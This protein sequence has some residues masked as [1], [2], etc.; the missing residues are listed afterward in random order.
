MESRVAIAPPN[1][2]P[3]E[4]DSIKPAMLTLVELNQRQIDGLVQTVPGGAR[5]VQDIYPLTPLQEGLLF[6]NLMSKQSDGYIWSTLLHVQSRTQVDELIR[7]LQTAIDR[8]DVLRSAMFWEQLPRPVQVVYRTA[9][10]PVEELTL[11]GDRCAINQLQERAAAGAERWDLRQAP[12]IRLLIALDPSGPGWYALWQL[13]HVVCDYGSLLTVTAECVAYLNGCPDKI[14]VQGGFRDHVAHVLAD[15]M[16][17]NAEEFFRNKFSEISEP[18]A[19]FNLLDVH[20]DG[21]RIAEASQELESTFG[22]DIRKQARSLGVSSARLFHAAWGLVVARSS[23]RNDVVFGTVLRTAERKSAQHQASVGMFINTLPLRLRLQGVTAA[24][25]IA[26]TQRELAE[27]LQYKQFPLAVAQRASGILGSAPLFTTLLNFRHTT[28]DSRADWTSVVGIQVV[29]A[30]GARTNY[31]I[32]LTVDDSGDVFS[33]TAQTDGQLDPQRVLAYLSTATQS[34]LDALQ[35]APSE[36][37]L[38]LTVLPESERRQILELFNAT[39][40]DY[41]R[42]KLVHELFEEQ[43][44]RTP[45]AVA[46]EF[47]EQRL[48]YA[49]LN[50]GANRLARYLLNQGVGPDHVVG[51]CVERGLEMVMGLLGILKSGGAFLPLDPNYPIERLRHMLEDAVP[52]IV[53]TQEELWGLL[54][55]TDA[56]VISLH[57][58]LRETA[59]RVEENVS[60]GDLGLSAQNLVYIIYTSGSTGQPKGTAM[61][62]RSMV[63]LI[64]WHRKNFCSREQQRVLQ[65]AAL[66]FD[67][68]FQE[69]F[70]TLCTGGTLVLLDEWLR[71]DARALTEFLSHHSIQRL[72]VP[73]LML[74]SLAECANTAD[75]VPR[76]LQD[77]ITAGE[78]LRISPE[79][80]SLFEK[81]N[82]CRLH[83]HYGP[84]E[85]HVVTALTL[86]GDSSQWPIL[87]SIGRPISNTQIYVLDAQRQPVPIDVTGEVHIGGAGVARGYLNQPELTAQRF[88]ADPFSADPRARLY[89]TGDLGRWRAN[90]SLEY[91]GRND[92]QVKIR[93][94]RVEPG[95]IEAQLTQHAYVKDAT[96]IAREDVPGQKRLV[97]YVTWHDQRTASPE[98]LRT[99]LKVMLPEYMIP[100]A[101]VTV[102]S[103]PLTPNGKLDREGLPV[104][105]LGAYASQNFEPPQGAIEET[106]AGIWQELLRVERVGRNDNFFSLGGHSLLATRVISHMRELLHVDLPVGVL[107]VAPTVQELSVRAE[108]EG[109]AQSAQEALWIAGLSRH[110][111]NDINEMEDDAVLAEVTEL[112]KE[113]SNLNDGDPARD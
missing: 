69:T 29:P 32:T 109:A 9:L 36:P 47:Q 33:L 54:P 27:L 41:P 23:G 53:L 85:T 49:E 71:R 21:T 5:N 31:P 50:K 59:G 39:T 113:F 91:L 57:A 58:M 28:S 80:S 42:E 45:D 55:A 89:R 74:Q 14:P 75:V 94:F 84:T 2:I 1:L 102:G 95:E 25:L 105:D 68:A 46:V 40:S 12:L 111:R 78:Q 112:Q 66:S 93:G 20:G 83:N 67:V 82:G 8:H 107:F 38:R 90:G 7:A 43:V 92:D 79:I 34:L 60:A 97:A 18:T 77:V 110:L 101:F 64:E 15:T 16:T 52:R 103:L 48:T 100:S 72:F 26:L 88:E 70:S 44:D 56:E 24:E 76:S 104:P 19:P 4:C 61:S 3:S 30:P 35:R 10:L 87:P 17:R 13:H 98:E 86:A 51:I 108:I 62:H 65:F 37:A 81:L 63:N 6:H 73:P 96:V 11:S 106:V 99:H 22:N